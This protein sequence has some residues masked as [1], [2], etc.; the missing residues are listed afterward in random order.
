MP[1]SKEVRARQHRQKERVAQQHAERRRVQKR[2]RQVG[3][4]AGVI[5]LVIIVT[6]G[7]AAAGKNDS[8]VVVGSSSS[9]D[10]P[11]TPTTA[12]APTTVPPQPAE[13]P[14]VGLKDTLPKGSPGILLTPGPAPTK[15]TTTDYTVGTGALVKPNAKVT[16]NY[17]GVACSTGKIFDSSYSRNEPFPVDLSGGVI[18][19]WLKGI[20]G[21]KIGGVRVL[22]I[23]SSLAYG[24]AGSPPKIGPNEAL[25][26][27]VAAVKL[28]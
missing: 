15:L 27:L 11:T 8:K 19:G 4:A 12:T 28:G 5:V 17:V 13:K 9:T 20:P 22:G 3:G 21:M 6:V 18:D 26:F 24:A 2:R 7:L 14:C 23:P 16:V 1:S 10:V 25:Y